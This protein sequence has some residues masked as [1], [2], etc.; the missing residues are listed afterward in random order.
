MPCSPIWS[1]TALRWAVRSATRSRC[2]EAGG[3]GATFQTPVS[4]AK[5]TET[6][7]IAHRNRRCIDPPEGT[8]I[9][10]CM[11]GRAGNPATP[12]CAYECLVSSNTYGIMRNT[13]LIAPLVLLSPMLAT[14]Q[15][16]EK[17]DLN[18]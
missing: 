18:V 9:I 13:L 16:T 15:Q 10:W 11:F 4:A 5:A 6:S 8:S 14:A 17:V 1:I 3:G 7:A 2:Q 12:L